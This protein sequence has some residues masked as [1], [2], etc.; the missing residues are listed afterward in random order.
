MEEEFLDGKPGNRQYAQPSV[1]QFSLP[2]EELLYLSLAREE[3]EGIEAKSIF[4]KTTQD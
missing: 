3:S 1:E 2:Q 4:E